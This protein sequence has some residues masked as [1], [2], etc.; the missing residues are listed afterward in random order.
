MKNL[1]QFITRYSNFLIFLILEVV[2]FILI[3]TTNH[4]QQSATW[5]AA[6]RFVAS[7]QQTMTNISDYFSLRKENEK[8]LQENADLK[9]QLMLMNNVLESNHEREEQYIYSHLDW[10][11]IPAKVI[12]ITTHKQHNYLTINKGQ[13]DGI[14][15]DMGV[16]SQDGVVGIV[17]AA[18]ERYALVVPLIHTE[19][20]VSCRI[21]ANDNIGRTHWLGKDYRELQLEDISRH[22]VVNEGDTI[23][24][25]GLTP[26]FPY[27]IVVGTVIQN[28]LTDHDNYHRITL[29]IATDYRK[30][31]YVQVIHNKATHSIDNKEYNTLW[32]GSEK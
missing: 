27:G 21:Q 29:Q 9:T 15:V 30:L 5:S 20:N 12:G 23:I 10:E 32:S 11:Y 14:E 26:V 13:R 4:Y 16:V 24:T 1:L 8:L 25:S 18:G 19:V 3:T 22:I 17:S 31:N 28:Q 6:N 7:I 2:A